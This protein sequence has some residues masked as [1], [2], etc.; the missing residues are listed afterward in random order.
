MCFA[1]IFKEGDERIKLLNA[2]RP[3]SLRVPLYF[4]ITWIYQ[5][6]GYI[7]MASV[8]L[9]SDTLIP[10]LIIQLCCQLKFL[11]HRLN[12]FPCRV[13]EIQNSLKCGMLKEELENSFISKTITHHNT[14]FQ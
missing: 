9:A 2:W 12:D 11:Q 13:Q 6:L 10:G 8:H 4:W 14:I 5:F 7:V 3:Y 1:V